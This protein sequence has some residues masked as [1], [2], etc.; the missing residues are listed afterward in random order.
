MVLLML[1]RGLS[2]QRLSVIENNGFFF[3][4]QNKNDE[5]IEAVEKK[6]VILQSS[7]YFYSRVNILHLERG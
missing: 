6:K 3:P 2:S 5:N 7:I 1:F 4:S